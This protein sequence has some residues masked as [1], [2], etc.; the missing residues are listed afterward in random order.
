[1]KAQFI[2]FTGSEWKFHFLF[3]MLFLG[4][5]ITIGW[6][7]FPS[8]IVIPRSAS[9]VLTLI[10]PIYINALILIP[11]YLK[12]STWLKYV[13]FLLMTLFLAKVLNT[14]FLVI[15]FIL[16]GVEFNFVSEFNK[17]FIRDFT[18]LDKFVFGSTVMIIFISFAYR[19]GKDWI[20]NERIKEKLI[21][22][23][24]SMELTLLK[25]QVNPHFLFNTLNNIYA[26]ALEEKAENTAKNISKLG[27]L[28]RYS[29]H[30]AQSDFIQLKK[31]IEYIE[32]YVE[33]QKLRSTDADSIILN[34]NVGGPEI[35]QAYIAP[36][37]L[38][39]FI[40][41]AF[42]YGISTSN[43][44]VIS[45]DIS[46]S[47]GKLYMAVKNSVHNNKRFT[48]FGLGLA[49]VKDRLRL[50]YSN[51]HRLV[52]EQKNNFYY[53]NLELKLNDD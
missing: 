9:W 23:K 17:W 19:I 41:N 18:R 10:I 6:S 30:D 38:I 13:V 22:E 29:L 46:F 15:P 36:M 7:D 28:M 44:S 33:M 35:Q 25:S 21:S 51:R 14:L 8:R 42:K 34:V 32:Q 3:W 52:Y 39:P 53:V 12:K 11:K 24:L 1:M 27:T 47:D 40:E 45:I 16:Q 48:N 50:I 2:Q 20:V 5:L 43:V 31:E 49:N 37:I 4:S 26:I